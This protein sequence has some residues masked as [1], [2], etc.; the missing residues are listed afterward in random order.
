MTGET[1]HISFSGRC[2]LHT[3]GDSP[4]IVHCIITHL[5]QVSQRRK[6]GASKGQYFLSQYRCQNPG[7][8]VK[9]IASWVYIFSAY[10]TSSSPFFYRAERVP[11]KG[12][13]VSISEAETDKLSVLW[14]F[15]PSCTS[16]SLHTYSISKYPFH[17]VL[18]TIY[19]PNQILC[20]Y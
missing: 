10:P 20:V 1:L 7:T 2:F 17:A 5:I 3:R 11:R 13:R 18:P 6:T 4:N 15:S 12:K 14:G 8:E 9:L 19:K 16:V